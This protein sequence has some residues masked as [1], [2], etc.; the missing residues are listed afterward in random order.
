MHLKICLN[1]KNIIFFYPSGLLFQ[2]NSDV[3]YLHHSLGEY[4]RLAAEIGETTF[5]VSQISEKKRPE[6]TLV[7]ANKQQ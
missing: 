6:M 2:F 5:V 7:S 1:K 4:L 3:L